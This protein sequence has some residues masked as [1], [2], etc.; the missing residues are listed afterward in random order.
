M[1]AGEPLVRLDARPKRDPPSDVTPAAS[2]YRTGPQFR[3][4]TEPAG[5]AFLGRDPRPLYNGR[6]VADVLFVA[7]F[8]LG[9]PM[10]FGVDMVADDLPFHRD[11][12][13][14]RRAASRCFSSRPR[15]MTS[16]AAAKGGMIRA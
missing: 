2:R 4:L 10:V 3:F 11:I 16:R 15:K 9:N 1:A 13:S 7:A 14:A 5:A 6:R 12:V 8:K